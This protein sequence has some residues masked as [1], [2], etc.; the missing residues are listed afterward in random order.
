MKLIKTASGK[1]QIKMSRKEWESIGKKAGWDDSY[2]ELANY[3][4]KQKAFYL[5]KRYRGKDGTMYNYMELEKMDADE[6]LYELMDSDPSNEKSYERI[7]ASLQKRWDG[8]QHQ[9]YLNL[10]EIAMELPDSDSWDRLQELGILPF[11]Q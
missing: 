10:Y 5:D 6:H 9:E 11:K 4:P 3:T 7:I 1:K 8:N 2:P